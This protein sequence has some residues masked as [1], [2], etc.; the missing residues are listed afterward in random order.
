MQITIPSAGGKKVNK[1]ELS[2]RSLNHRGGS[3]KAKKQTTKTYGMSA[4]KAVENKR[5]KRG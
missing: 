3:K 4:I 5:I 1:T 2:F